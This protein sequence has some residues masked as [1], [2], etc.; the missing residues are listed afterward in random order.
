MF[1]DIIRQS[2]LQGFKNQVDGVGI[3]THMCL[4]HGFGNGAVNTAGQNIALF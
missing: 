2:N 4:R 3:H 1:A